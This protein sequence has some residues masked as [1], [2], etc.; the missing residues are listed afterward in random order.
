M[1]ANIQIL[2]AKT[3]QRCLAFYKSRKNIKLGEMEVTM[4]F[5]EKIIIC[6]L[7][8]SFPNVGRLNKIFNADS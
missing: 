4:R 5:P 7:V 3:V 8:T 1:D 6:F 2:Q